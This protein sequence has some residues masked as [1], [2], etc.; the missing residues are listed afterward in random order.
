MKLMK[1]G[2]LSLRTSESQL[3]KLRGQKPRAIRKDESTLESYLAL[4]RRKPEP[5]EPRFTLDLDLKTNVN[6]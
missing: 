6:Q 5:E 4:A 1:S 3:L 2:R